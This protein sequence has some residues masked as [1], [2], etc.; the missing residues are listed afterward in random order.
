MLENKYGQNDIFMSVPTVVNK[1]GIKE[2]IELDLEEYDKAKFQK[3]AQA[4][5]E[6][7]G[8]L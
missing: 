7:R 1:Q 3:S 2:I 6:A 5:R 8:V 4:L